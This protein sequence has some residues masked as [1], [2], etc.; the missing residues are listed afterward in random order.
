MHYVGEVEYGSQSICNM[1]VTQNLSQHSCRSHGIDLKKNEQISER[2]KMNEEQ[3][4]RKI[5]LV[6]NHYHNAD[7]L[8]ATSCS[9]HLQINIFD[10]RIENSY[11]F[12]YE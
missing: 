12:D 7:R 2:K 3:K 10:I 9:L 4:S 6:C 11:H 8:T 1:I 5:H